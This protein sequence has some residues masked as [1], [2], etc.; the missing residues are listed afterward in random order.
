MLPRTFL[1]QLIPSRI[2]EA[3]R[4]VEKRLW[5][6]IPATE[7]SV[8]QTES[9][10]EHRRAD[11]ISS[12]RFT[13]V[14]SAPFHWGPKF[15]QRWFRLALPPAPDS[16]TRYLVWED[17]AEATA[18][19]EGAPYYGLDVAH[20]HCPL[21]AGASAILI[22]AVCVKTG[23]WLKN[24]QPLD[25]AGSLYTPPRLTWRDDLA[26]EVYHD[27]SVLLEIIE[28]ECE[29]YQPGAKK[30][31]TD[32]IRHT[33]A[34][35]R[36]SPLFRRWCA[37]LDV[38]IDVFDRQGL[39]A[40]G[41]ELKKIYAGFPAE[42]DALH[43]VLTGHAH[44]DLVWLWPERV[45]EFKAVH[46]WAT[47]TRLMADYPEFKFGYS[48]PASYAAVARRAPALFQQVKQLIAAGRW[49][50]TGGSYVEF[51][52]QLP[53]GEG[54]LRTLRLGQA[55]F[56]KLRGTPSKVCWLPDVFGY[57]SALPQLLRGFGIESFFTTKLSWNTVNRM[58]HTS[59]RWKGA[60]GSTVLSHVI[61]LHDYN[62]SV[63]I[64]NL[65][66]DALHH[67][68]AAVHPEFLVP[69]GYGDGGGGPTPEMCERVRR[70][71]NLAGAPRTAWGSIEPFFARLAP[72]ADELPEVSGELLFELHRG[73]FTTHGM[74]KAA[75]RALERALQTLEAAHVAGRRGP[76]DEQLWRRLSVAQFHDHIPGSSIWEVYA[77]AIPELHQLVTE[78]TQLTSTALPH[79]TGHGWF[80]PLPIPRT[81]IDGT[82]CLELAPLSGAP[83]A[84]LARRPVA[85]P[86]AA[87]HAL[88]SERVQAIFTDEGGLASLAI[89]GQACALTGAGHALS[90][91]PDHPAK[92]E[93]WDIDRAALSSGIPATRLAQSKASVEGLTAST[94]FTYRLAARSTVAVRYSVTAGEP[95]LRIEYDID[96]QDPEMLLKGVIST[97]YT[98]RE[99]RFGAPFGSTLR[100]QTP[101]YSREEAQW[102]VPASRWMIVMDDSQSEGIAVI[103]EAKYGFSVRE[104]VAAVSLLRSAYVTGADEHP[105][106]RPTPNRPR[107]SDLGR[108]QVR[109]ALARFTAQTPREEQPA[110][111]A[112]I[113]FA[114]CLPYG[115]EAVGCG[116]VGLA[117]AS[118]LVPSWAEP[119]A[120]GIWVLRLHET[121][122]RRGNTTLDVARGWQARVVPLGA[123]AAQI[124]DR[125][126]PGLPGSLS[127]A[128]G[129]YQVVSIAFANPGH[130]SPFPSPVRQ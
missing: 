86:K 17:Q 35:H 44:I 21:P 8:E 75:F 124:C 117:G 1:T 123:D 125:T 53:C 72:A 60:D 103:T 30:P 3:L 87:E 99:A 64:R 7:I 13:P 68:Q 11:E 57:T 77:E 90:A 118:S 122:G 50:A 76:I 32:L 120:P 19:V 126:A 5:Q 81:W 27:L 121:L 119:V 52:T 39:A 63:G 102:E 6:P 20:R 12:L 43:A 112:D 56:L 62:E 93:A 89:D 55:D 116:L 48:Q 2:A 47:Q 128:Y 83:L 26:W 109:I 78:A 34:I 73:V 36:A 108:Q 23:L 38:A 94:T 105:Q 111:L 18:Y 80:N 114:P 15:A 59:F 69:T 113:L 49:E 115:G 88:S 130:A 70:L 104:G 28:I 110:A 96:W 54:L 127:V 67:Q 91:Y 25:E 98:G 46:S 10:I 31:I 58:P 92:F 37:L 107:H 14:P 101:G 16:R 45:G 41:L 84:A 4:R 65:R 29:D 40:F 74:L 97:G 100:G 82:E 95:V 24:A 66:E 71:S 42:R 106:I 85:A 33:P 61:L 129:P 79:G 22:E 51:D 9:L